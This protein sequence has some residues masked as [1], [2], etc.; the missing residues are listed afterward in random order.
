[1][2]KL[3]F[4]THT[5]IYWV[6]L[7]GVF[8]LSLYNHVPKSL[9]LS[10]FP[11]SYR[12]SVL[13]KKKT[14]HL[15]TLPFHINPFPDLERRLKCDVWFQ[16]RFFWTGGV[17]FWNKSKYRLMLGSDVTSSHSP[18]KS[19]QSVFHMRKWE[20]SQALSACLEL[21]MRTD[22]INCIATYL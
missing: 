2:H 13:T 14:S 21:R 9:C 4:Q 20:L 1:M 19:I 8:S 6:R 11:K 12:L 18:P 22:H 10:S 16:G 3:C 15:S 17:G 7:I 5:I